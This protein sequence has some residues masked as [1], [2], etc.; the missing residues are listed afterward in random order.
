MN[1][2]C[3]VQQHERQAQV[4]SCHGR[5]GNETRLFC[6]FEAFIVHGFWQVDELAKLADGP[7]GVGKWRGV[8]VHLLGTSVWQGH[9]FFLRRTGPNMKLS[10]H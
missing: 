9:M 2:L 1:K 10:L 6:N 5:N 7:T 8:G 3:L 4:F